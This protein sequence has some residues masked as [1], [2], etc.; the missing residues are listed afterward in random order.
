MLSTG[1]SIQGLQ[2]RYCWTK[3]LVKISWIYTFEKKQSCQNQP[4]L[5]PP[6]HQDTQWFFTNIGDNAKVDSFSPVLGE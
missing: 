2:I 6:I 3:K 5:K 4:Q 1:F